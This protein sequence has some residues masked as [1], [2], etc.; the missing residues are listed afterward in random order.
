MPG[1]FGNSRTGSPAGPGNETPPPRERHA[2]RGSF[3]KIPK[4]PWRKKNGPGIRI[5]SFRSRPT[6][7][8]RACRRSFPC[9]GNSGSRLHAK[10]PRRLPRR[11]QRRS[12]PRDGNGYIQPRISPFRR[13]AK[14]GRHG[15]ASREPRG[16]RLPRRRERAKTSSPF[17]R[18]GVSTSV[19]LCAYSAERSIRR[20]MVWASRSLCVTTTRTVRSPRCISRSNSPTAAPVWAS[21]LPVG[22]SASKR[23]GS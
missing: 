20:F 17:G 21:R 10:V 6:I 3:R 5:F 8:R 22:S 12:L 15:R 1:R 14:W 9:G 4:E 11:G 2:P 13:P 16:A 7:L 18:P 19:P 23:S